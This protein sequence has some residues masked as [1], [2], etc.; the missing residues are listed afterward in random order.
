LKT[1][2]N[3]FNQPRLRKRL[4]RRENTN[5][6]CCIYNSTLFNLLKENR[7]NLLTNIFW[8]HQLSFLIFHSTIFRSCIRNCSISRDEATGSSFRNQG[9]SITRW[10]AIKWIY[11]WAILSAASW[12]EK[13]PSSNSHFSLQCLKDADKQ[14]DNIFYSINRYNTFQLVDQLH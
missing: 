14:T 8:R 11:M 2:F 5:L 6:V 3:E 10:T 9:Y 12:K 13:N 4:Q 7:S 1:H